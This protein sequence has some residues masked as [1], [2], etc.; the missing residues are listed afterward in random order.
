MPM[1]CPVIL[2]A[3]APLPAD[4]QAGDIVV[5]GRGL[6]TAPEE[7]GYDVQII[8][9]DRLSRVA[10]DRL[11]DVLGDVAGLQS[12][13]RS[14]SRSA[15]PTSQGLTLRGI[16]GNAASRA[17]LVLD[18]VPQADPFAGWIAFP[19]YAPGRLGRVRVTR[20]GGSGLWGA[21]A[22][23]GTVELESATPDQLAPLAAR[24][25]YG[26]RDSFDGSAEASLKRGRGFATL[27]AQYQRGAGFIPIVAGDRGP[28][29]RPAPYE[30]ASVAARAVIAIAGHAELQT[31]IQAFTDNRE[32]GY[33][34]S[35]NSSKGADASL[36]LVGTGDWGWS[37]LGYVQTRAFA[38]RFASIDAARTTATLTLDQYSVPGTGVGGR[39]EI[40]PPLGDGQ[41]LRIG[42]DV[43]SLSGKTQELFGY[44]AGSPTRRREA[45][46]ATLTAG[47][48]ANL[49]L[50]AGRVTFD[51]NARID[52]W[53]I[54]QAFLNETP[55]A[56]GP[57]AIAT[58]Y[59]GR[60][61]W[62]PTGRLGIGWRMTDRMT[63]RA[64]GYRGW[65]LP[66]LNELYRPFRAG[67]DA[68][69]AN[70]ALR[71]E[72]LVGGE[73]GAEWRPRGGAVRLSATLFYNR[74]DD[75]IA[76]VTVAAG[77]VACPGAGQV[78][79]AGVC[80]RR[81]NLPAIEAAGVEADA[82]ATFGAVTVRLAYAYT[83]SRVRG[84][85]ASAML[86]GL[87][88]AQ[89]PAHQVSATIG[90]RAPRSVMASLTPRYVSSQYEDDQNS[91]RLRGAFTL[92]GT[93][94]VPLSRSLSL[95]F[96]TEN[97][98]DATVETGYSNVAIERSRLRTLWAGLSFRP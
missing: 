65:R 25:A 60:S 12:F 84:T 24:I 50:P 93:L 13:R 77:P 97:L 19:A 69:A 26:S 78:S 30:Q 90:W 15:N 54:A 6:D 92:D 3:A 68:T 45:G 91:R 11:E 86:N 7:R 44:Q 35:A 64:A 2:A 37:L 36:R 76:N 34:N 43:R 9:R 32:R 89:T 14:D 28:I 27:S 82:S 1:L 63:L 74:L 31:N 38:S 80:R 81:D 83:H 52:A 46:G 41:W 62:E 8:A 95:T 67:A 73:A 18:G 56:S 70:A 42:A 66:T 47:G 87:V 10:S 40:S 4:P 22:E 20:G 61:G 48:F 59:A 85:G 23:T 79:A 17:L 75:A 53:R 29:D 72:T 71:P 96:A 21:G 94:A 39:V 33:A 49:T 58:R 5:T 57:A 16:G 51:L 98:F 88:P 55:L